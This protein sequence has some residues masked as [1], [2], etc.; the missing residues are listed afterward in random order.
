M[1]TKT[2]TTLDVQPDPAPTPP[3]ADGGDDQPTPGHFAAQSLDLAFKANLARLTGGVSPAGLARV[4]FDWLSHLA[5]SP[6]KQ[7]ELVEKAARKFVR[8]SRYAG[9]TALDSE[10]AP[11]HRPT[12]TGSALRRQQLAAL[13]LQF[14]L[15]VLSAESTMVAQRHDRDR[16][17]ESG[18][19]ARRVVHRPTDDGPL[20]SL[21]HPMAE[22]GSH[23]GNDRRR[24]E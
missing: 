3:V 4:Y 16:R 1:A 8:F 19:R 11:L 13:A 9:Q 10:H 5:L 21:Q 14:L 23:R 24:A 2:A 15:P 18:K 12:A 20:V 22:S 17:T 6:G 7:L